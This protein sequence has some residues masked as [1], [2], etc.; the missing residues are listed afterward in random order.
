MVTRLVAE[1]ELDFANAH[2]P[3]MQSSVQPSFC[4]SLAADHLLR[5][6]H[7]SQHG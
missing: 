3:G 1:L 6:Q 5:N 2:A 4:R 7:A